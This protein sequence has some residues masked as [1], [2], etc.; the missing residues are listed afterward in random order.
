[1][2]DGYLNTV[3]EAWNSVPVM[4]GVEAFRLLYCKLRCTAKALKSWSTKSVGSVRA[5]A[6][7]IVFRLDSAQD[8]RSL[9][10]REAALR[11]KARL[12]SLGLASL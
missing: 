10:A 6:K 1:M 7:E 8:H 2:C 12:C 11:R 3:E 9:L 5:I 4:P